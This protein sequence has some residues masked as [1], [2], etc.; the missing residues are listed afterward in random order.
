M[1]TDIFSRIE[2]A[3]K[4]L[5]KTPDDVKTIFVSEKHISDDDLV[6]TAIEMSEYDEVIQEY[7]NMHGVVPN[8]FRTA[9]KIILGE[10]KSEPVVEN[11]TASERSVLEQL[12]QSSRPIQQW[13]D[14]EVLKSYIESD[15]ED[16]ESELN[17]RA[18]GRRF[19]VLTGKEPEEIDIDASLRMLKRARKEDIPSFIKTS[20]DEI[21]NIYRVEDYHQ[22]NRVRSESPLRPNVALFD[23]FCP[24]SNLNF[25]G[26]DQESRQYIRLIRDNCGEQSRGE[27]SNIVTVAREKGFDGLKSLY[28]EIHD[29]YRTAFIRGTLPTLKMV[30]KVSSKYSTTADPF[31]AKYG[32]R[33]F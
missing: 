14:E 11:S 19:I 22:D 20:D 5:G 3:A 15:R 24:V 8:K 13:S 32:K 26:I 17:K 4:I 28:P 29:F 33:T 10:N 21:I 2:K 27:E 31:N 12:L 25:A 9:I 18:K 23:D 30:E 16:L 6:V 1:S 7:E